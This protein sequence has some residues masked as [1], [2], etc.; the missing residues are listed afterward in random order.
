MRPGGLTGQGHLGRRR[1]GDAGVERTGAAP[2]GRVA[3]AARAAPGTAAFDAAAACRPLL[4]C[5]PSVGETQD[6]QAD[7]RTR[8]DTSAG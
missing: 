3:K 8:H 2:K 1:T 6:G 4:E 5:A 7:D